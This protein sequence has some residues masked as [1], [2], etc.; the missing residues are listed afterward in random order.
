MIKVFERCNFTL[1][2]CRFAVQKRPCHIAAPAVAE[3]ARGSAVLCLRAVW[4][5]R[6]NCTAASQEI[7]QASSQLQRQLLHLHL[8]W[9]V[10]HDPAKMRWYSDTETSLYCIHPTLLRH[11]SQNEKIER[12]VKFHSQYEFAGGTLRIILHVSSR[13][14]AAGHRTVS[15]L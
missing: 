3:A 14:L 9:P 7:I 5:V 15:R 11:Q 4:A 13:F 2:L 6:R 10:P 8:L 1:F 12:L